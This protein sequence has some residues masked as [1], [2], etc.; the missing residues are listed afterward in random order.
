MHKYVWAIFFV[1]VQYVFI[2]TY[3]KTLRTVSLIEREIC[4]CKQQYI[5]T[6]K[7]WIVLFIVKKDKTHDNCYVIS[8]NGTHSGS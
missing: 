3:V 4:I 1:N 6:Y 2:S 8:W 5:S 7:C